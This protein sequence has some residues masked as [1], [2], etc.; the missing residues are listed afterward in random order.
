MSNKRNV[1]LILNIFFYFLGSLVFTRITATGQELKGEVKKEIVDMQDQFQWWPT[2]SKPGV[3]K[4]QEHSGYWWWPKEPGEV[5]PW[6]NRGYIFVNKIIFDYKADEYAPI[7]ETVEAVQE[8]K[9]SLLIK[10]IIKN[11]K[12]YFDYNKAQLREDH[13]PVLDQTVKSLSNNPEASILLTGNCDKRGTD[14]YNMKLGKKRGE[15][16]KAY[17]LEKGIPEDRILI[18]SR[19]KLDAVAP[20]NDLV[21]MQKDRNAQFMVAEVKEIMIPAK[22]QSRL[23]EATEIEVATELE[24]GKYI[25]E[26]EVN[27]ETGVE[28]STRDYIIQ[29]NDTLSKIAQHELGAGYRWKYLYELNKDT[30]KDPNKLKVGQKIIIPIE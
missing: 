13:Y 21:G 14:E 18:V 11:V 5:R 27:V 9:P 17:L 7:V 16:V 20:I 3:F 6:G 12:I 23:E 24:E 26:K 28:V 19:G 4:D 30:I 29:K 8:L 15:S 1:F 10:K 2:D 25:I 22:E